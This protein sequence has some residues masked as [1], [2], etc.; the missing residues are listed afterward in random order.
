MSNIGIV[1][2]ETGIWKSDQAAEGPLLTD[3]DFI[4][5]SDLPAGSRF[6]VSD[7][8][9]NAVPLSHSRPRAG[10][11]PRRGALCGGGNPLTAHILREILKGHALCIS[12]VGASHSCSFRSSRHAGRVAGQQSHLSK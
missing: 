9:K 7:S 2:R 10:N 12:G 3:S 1:N 4:F 11:T 5:I 8:R 6:P